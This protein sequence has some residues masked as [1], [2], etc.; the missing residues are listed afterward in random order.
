MS[1]GRYSL[2]KAARGDAE[3]IAEVHRLARETGYAG[4]APAETLA[5][6]IARTEPDYWRVRLP[7]LLLRGD[8]VVV[9]EAGNNRIV[10]FAHRSGERLDRLYVSPAWWGSG[11]AQAL[12]ALLRQSAAVVGETRLTL[13]CHRDNTRA[14]RFYTRL[15]GIE[16]GERAAD[17]ADGSP[18]AV[19]DIVWEL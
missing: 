2:R 4:I 3:G 10:G 6:H 7:E 13:D 15:G 19:I 12:F 14:R 11:V 1:H 18:A 8:E 17:F 9:A 16:N 5:D